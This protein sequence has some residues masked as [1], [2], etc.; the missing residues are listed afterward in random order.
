MH[1]IETS[2]HIREDPTAPVVQGGDDLE[3][4]A[5]LWKRAGDG[6]A[7]AG[8]GVV[9]SLSPG[10]AFFVEAAALGAFPFGALILAPQAGVMA[11]F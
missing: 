1:D 2:V 6:F 5:T 3:H 11:G 10:T 9:V 8:A 4:E 7:G